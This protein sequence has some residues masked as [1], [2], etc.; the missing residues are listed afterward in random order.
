LRE[1]KFARGEGVDAF[2][3]AVV[4]REVYTRWAF[5]LPLDEQTTAPELI[6]RSGALGWRR[7]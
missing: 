7:S 1:A 4:M 2:G 6:R 3:L 5:D